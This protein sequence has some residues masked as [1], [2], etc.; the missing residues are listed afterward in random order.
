[1]TP[2]NASVL[3]RDVRNVG[4]VTGTGAAARS[5]PV[6]EPVGDQLPGLALGG[7]LLR[8]EDP[9]HEGLPSAQ[10]HFGRREVGEC[11]AALAQ[12]T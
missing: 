7:T 5:I 12:V 6:E 11:E 3:G 4:L 10:R 2:D 8:K 1:M 9:D